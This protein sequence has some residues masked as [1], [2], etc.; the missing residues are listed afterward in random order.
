MEQQ[1]KH[2]LWIVLLIGVSLWPLWIAANAFW[3]FLER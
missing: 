3:G 2:I 1:P